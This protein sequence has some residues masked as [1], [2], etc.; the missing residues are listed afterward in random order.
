M[1][2]AFATDLS[3]VIQYSTLQGINHKYVGFLWIF[4]GFQC[5]LQ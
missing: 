1:A 5:L 4:Y 3:D 2:L